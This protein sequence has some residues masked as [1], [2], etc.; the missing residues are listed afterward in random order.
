MAHRGRRRKRNV[1]RDAGGKSRG[2]PEAVDPATIAVRLR[3]LERC[4]VPVHDHKIALDA[5]A[6]FTLGRLLLRHRADPG[7]PGSINAQQY[8]AGQEWATLVR[9]HAAIMGYE[10]HN[11]QSPSFSVAGTR[12]LSCLKEP[13]EA[14]IIAVR[15]RW[16]DCY[17][18]LMDVCRTH[19]LAV[20]DIIYA[21]CIE[22]RDIELLSRED[23]GNL[24]IGL[25]ALARILGLTARQGRRRIG[26]WSG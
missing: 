25:N 11:P 4:G 10:L 24:R 15:R 7:D 26:V 13:E 1:I 20:R 12:G 22:N 19:G 3:E 17:H 21:V 2:V 18:G 14:E 8:H 5:L 16:S 23:F 6:G 9:S